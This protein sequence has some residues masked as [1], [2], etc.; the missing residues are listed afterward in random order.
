[1]IYTVRLK[2][3]GKAQTIKAS[4]ELEARAK[5][6]EERGFNYRVFANKLEIEQKTKQRRKI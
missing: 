4:N 1:M 6:C 3:I 2:N 5:Y